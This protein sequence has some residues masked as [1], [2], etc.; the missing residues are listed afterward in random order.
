MLCREAGSK[1]DNHILGNQNR[2]RVSDSSRRLE[3]ISHAN[4]SEKLKNRLDVRD[5]KFHFIRA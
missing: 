2:Q 3:K 5:K 4:A 1:T